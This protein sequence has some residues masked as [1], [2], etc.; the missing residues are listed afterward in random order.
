MIAQ[1]LVFRL[2]SQVKE[3]EML[4]MLDSSSKKTDEME[5]YKKKIKNISDYIKTEV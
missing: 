3:L 5:N 2:D 4:K 1:S